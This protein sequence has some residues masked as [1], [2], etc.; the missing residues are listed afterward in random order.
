MCFAR[1]IPDRNPFCVLRK[2]I[3]CDYNSQAVRQRISTNTVTGKQFVSRRNERGRQHVR[4]R[5]V[6]RCNVYRLFALA[7]LERA[8]RK[9]RKGAN[10][11]AKAGITCTYAGLK[12]GS[13]NGAAYNKPENYTPITQPENT[14]GKHTCLMEWY[15]PEPKQRL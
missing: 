14:P 12:K 3:R 11:H 7:R 2:Q 4:D 10:R 8:S 6:H 15:S 1:D 5:R 13:C 9:S